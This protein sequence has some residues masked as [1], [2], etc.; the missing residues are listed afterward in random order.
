MKKRILSMLL[1]LVVFIGAIPAMSIESD[2]IIGSVLKIGFTVCKSVINGTIV[3]AKNLDHYNGNVGK[4]VLGQFKNIAADLTG[5][6][7]G[8]DY[9]DGSESGE[10]GTGEGEQQP[11]QE[12]INSVALEEIKE[13]MQIISNKLDE[14]NNAIYQLEST[15]NSGM[16]ELSGQLS[17]LYKEINKLSGTVSDTAQLNRYYTYLT[18][19]F[20]FFNQYYEAISHYDEQLTYTMKGNHTEKYI[21]NVFDQFY[22]L[23]NV[24]YTGNLHSAVT[25]LGKYIRGEYVSADSGSVI[26]VLS[27]YYIQSY[28]LT[29]TDCTEEEAREEAAA[30]IEDMVGYIYYAYCTGVYYEDAVLMY[31]SSYM[32]RMNIT[33]YVTDFGTYISSEQI[34]D[35]YLSISD[36]ALLTAGS[37]L[38]SLLSNYPNGKLVTPYFLTKDMSTGFTRQLSLTG[39]NMYLRAMNRDYFNTAYLPD[40]ATGLSDYFSEDLQDAFLDITTYSLEGGDQDRDGVLKLYDGNRLE[41]SLSGTANL[42]ACVLDHV[43]FTIPVNVINIWDDNIGEGTED[44]PW[45]ISDPSDMA[46]LWQHPYDHFLLINDISMSEGDIN[47]ANFYGVFDGNGYTIS[48][49][50]GGNSCGMFSHL[51]GT[52]RNLTLKNGTISTHNYRSAGVFAGYMHDNALIYRCRAVDCTVIVESDSASQ[53]VSAGG[54]AGYMENNAAIRSCAVDDVNIR[55]TGKNTICAGGIVGSLVDGTVSDCFVNIDDPD[56]DIKASIKD[57]NVGGI[58]GGIVG[59][60]SGHY[61]IHDAVIALKHISISGYTTGVILG[62]SANID[63][64]EVSGQLKCI[65][66]TEGYVFESAWMENQDLMRFYGGSQD[67]AKDNPTAFSARCTY[68]RDGK[69][70]IVIGSFVEGYVY[71][72]TSFLNEFEDIYLDYLKVDSNGVRNGDGTLDFK[73]LRNNVEQLEIQT[74]YESGMCFDASGWQL[75]YCD[76]TGEYS[77]PAGRFSFTITGQNYNEA[78]TGETQVTFTLDSDTNTKTYDLRIAQNHLWVEVTTKEPTCTESGSSALMCVDCGKT[79]D[80]KTLAPLGHKEVIDPAVSANC[81]GDGLTEGSH[82]ERC[83]KVLIEQQSVAA[84]DDHGHTIVKGYEATCTTD[85]LT[86]KEYCEGCGLVHKE[87]QVIPALGHEMKSYTIIEATCTGGGIIQDKCERCGEYGDFKSID[88]LGHNWQTTVVEPTHTEIGYTLYHCDTC[89]E[90]YKSDYTAPIGHTFGTSKVTKAATCTAEGVMTYSCSC[91]NSH[92]VSIPKVAHKMVSEV[93]DPTCTDIGFT[94]RSCANCDYGYVEAYTAP[95]G[96]NFDHAAATCS[97]AATC[98]VCGAV[99]TEFNEKNH[100]AEATWDCTEKYHTCTYSCCGHVE[101]SREEHDWANGVCRSCGYTCAHV[102]GTATCSHL[103]V[104]SLCEQEYGELDPHNHFDLDHISAR[105]A[106]TDEEGNIE[107]WYCPDCGK[108]YKD[109]RG[110]TELKSSDLITE[111]LPYDVGKLLLWLLPFFLNIVGIVAVIVI[112][113]GKRKKAD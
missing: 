68:A 98:K 77:W 23:E 54:I 80:E 24:E 90:S 82:C 36:D 21:K 31:Q 112:V 2:A 94:T 30:A 52:V 12:A 105:A 71:P 67:D 99:S 107:H 4:C 85:G 14:T 91:G 50:T 73:P 64:V 74:D 22:H 65:D 25:K 51:Y 84:T 1:A 81:K 104:C 113:T 83:G 110:A 10:G 19:F 35:K 37:V 34:S 46:L 26:D 39:F 61:T 3:T 87:A 6:D 47:I 53:I 41:A 18:E 43:I 106:T 93:T 32:E 75:Y 100:E 7:I 76:E 49:W 102:G 88:A 108:S 5:L 66:R 92:T 56:V 62:E 86:D 11:T 8:E 58:V 42:H 96:H 57:G 17:E 72:D 13:T 45:I 60:A 38:S 79:K 69:Y 28:K 95:L 40:L 101:V 9:G 16:K 89:G 63:G 20:A 15:V 29:H 27:K 44:F 111:K 33:E 78:L 97:H 109:S 59:F 55:A 48:D 70:T 103:A